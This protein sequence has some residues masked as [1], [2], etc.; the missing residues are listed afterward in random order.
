MEIKDLDKTQ[1]TRSLS[2]KYFMSKCSDKIKKSL[3]TTAW[4]KMN[5]IIQKKRNLYILDAILD[6]IDSVVIKVGDRDTIK[7]EYNIAKL[8]QGIDGFIK[9]YCYFSCN[10]EFKQID[11]NKTLC[12]NNGDATKIL[13]MKNYKLG[14]VGKYIWN[15]ENFSALQS[16]LKQIIITLLIGFQKTGFIHNDTRLDNFL[17]D[18]IKETN[19]IYNNY[20]IPIY[21]LIVV[22]M[23]FENCLIAENKEDYY[24]LYTG[25][26]QILNE[27]DYK[28][29]L[30]IDNIDI[31]IKYIDTNRKNNTLI[32]INQIIT[33]IDELKFISK[34]L[35][36]KQFVYNPT[37]F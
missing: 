28:L 23:D 33:Y 31:I 19:I 34:K 2:S 27:L 32:N 5:S 15:Y 25:I 17:L 7:K 26:L 29:K 18:Y 8:L 11:I 37:I 35:P 16:I 20:N 24:F 36:P 9:Y 22:I 30:E 6:N 14:S 10:N 12:Y 1:H 21:G 13:V 3:D 4:L